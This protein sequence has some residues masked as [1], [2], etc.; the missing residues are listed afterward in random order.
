MGTTNS[1]S[2]DLKTMGIHP[3]C[4]IVSI[5]ACTFNTD[6]PFPP[7][8]YKEFYDELNWKNQGR[9]ISKDCINEFWKKQPK[10][11]R[12]AL[13]GT[14]NLKQSLVDFAKWLPRNPVVF[15]NGAAFDISFL[16]N[17]YR[18]CGL[19][20][21]WKFWN[22]LDCRTVSKIYNTKRGS[23]TVK[24]PEKGT[25]HTALDAAKNRA[26]WTNEYW[27]RLINSPSLSKQFLL[28]SAQIEQTLLDV[29]DG[30]LDG[31]GAYEAIR[32]IVKA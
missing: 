21:P 28:N 15:S 19:E 23:L 16:E 7:K 1:V 3:G 18:Q 22:I 4:A 13:K 5:G 17:A 2:I 29:Q 9:D 32:K 30:F 25:Q 11:V 6:E 27:R 20:I 31:K 12:E 24:F 8:N 14:K 10:E 26:N